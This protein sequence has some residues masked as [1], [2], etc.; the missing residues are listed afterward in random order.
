MLGITTQIHTQMFGS[1]LERAMRRK[2]N[3]YM[4]FDGLVSTP[5]GSVA[6]S[7]YG[8]EM[9]EGVLR[10]GDHA[11]DAPSLVPVITPNRAQ[12]HVSSG[13]QSTLLLPGEMAGS[14]PLF[15]IFAS[16]HHTI[17]IFAPSLPCSP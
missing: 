3:V 7:A 9:R 13:S 1:N 12:H 2:K 10:A 5:G 14:T 16:T 15:D 4:R 6:R 17:I 8:G 11:P